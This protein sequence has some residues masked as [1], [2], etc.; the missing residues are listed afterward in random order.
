MN[1]NIKSRRE[2]LK[3]LTLTGVNLMFYSCTVG[4]D[5][6]G[7][8]TIVINKPKELPKTDTVE[9]IEKEIASNN[10]I[11]V[12]AK[13]DNYNELRQGFNK[14]YDKKPAVIAL[15][16]NTLGVSEAIK[17][18][19][20]EGYK[21][22]IKSGGHSF[23]GFSSID[24]GM[25]INLSLM[26]SIELNEN[27]QAIVEPACLLKNLYDYLLP[28]NRI[29][30]AGSCGTVGVGGLALGGGYGFF[31]RKYGLT[32]D[33]LIDAEFVDGN[34]EIHKASE[35]ENL[36]WGLKGGGNGNYG[37]VTK[38]TFNTH[39]AP[40]GFTRYRFKAYKLDKERT[41]TLL[42]TYFEYSN[43]LSETCFAA[44]VLNHKT[45]VLLITNYGE[46]DEALNNMLE[47]FKAISDK[48]DLGTKKDLANSLKNYYGVQYP[49]YFKNASAGYYKGY[50]DI[51]T[52]L[53]EVLDK[54]F[55]KSGLIYQINTLGGNINNSDFEEKSCYPHR[56]YG[57]L[58]ELQAYWDKPSQEE[59]LVNTFE[60][61]QTELFNNG[62]TRQ[63]RNYPSLGFK[64][65]QTAYYGEENYAKLQE[66][67][68]QYDP[69]GVFHFEQIVKS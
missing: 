15:C 37:V 31:A 23:E 33:N 4:E 45:M 13:D 32:C 40:N 28:K 17:L 58:S 29:I 52:S 42:K 53:D 63:Y 26:N 43:K 68:Q 47:A 64:N 66:L 48:T 59:Y 24:G 6:N 49:I 67:K 9:V 21:V 44:F 60:E 69:K 36:L 30:P 18:A 62:I 14:R 27:N 51:E 11:Y 39:P 19:N 57:Y 20:Q 3:L 8:P 38:M 7:E 61:I 2:I 5:E 25:Q 34:G 10:V 12:Y 56:E 35:K 22:A 54:V 65:W 55:A 50:E 41:K 1:N 46:P 16:K